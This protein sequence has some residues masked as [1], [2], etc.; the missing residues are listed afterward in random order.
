[1]EKLEKV[2]HFEYLGTNTKHGRGRWYGNGDN[3][4]SGAGWRNDQKCSRYGAVWSRNM[5]TSIQTFVNQC[6]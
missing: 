3:K 2:T 4:T 5:V 6:L 1:M